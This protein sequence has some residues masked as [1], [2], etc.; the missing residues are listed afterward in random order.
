MI[1]TSIFIFWLIVG[2]GIG[3]YMYQDAKKR[4]L[5][6]PSIWI[7]IGLIFGLLGL[8]TYWYWHIKPKSNPNKTYNKKSLKSGAKTGK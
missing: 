3:I 6:N 5:A 1:D 4:K 7:W 2:L 8:V